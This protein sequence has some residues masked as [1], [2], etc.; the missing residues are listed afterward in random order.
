MSNVPAELVD[1]SL[2]ALEDEVP[3]WRKLPWRPGYVR[4]MRFPTMAPIGESDIAVDGA[5]EVITYHDV[6]ADI[7]DDMI[8][9][10]AMEKA[11]EAAIG[12]I[13]VAPHE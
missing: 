5:Q 1:L 9:R 12:A 3:C 7:A 2:N 13:S 8:V 4:L 10:F 6:P 11:L